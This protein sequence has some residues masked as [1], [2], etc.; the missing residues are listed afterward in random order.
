M[1]T[2]VLTVTA[3][4]KEYS[5]NL[6]CSLTPLQ[7]YYARIRIPQKPV[8]FRKDGVTELIHKVLYPSYI[9]VDS[10]DYYSLLS[11][12]RDHHLYSYLNL[13]GK[14]A[15]E[16]KRVSAKE[17][18]WVKRLSEISAAVF[19]DNRIH[20]TIG[21]L[22]GCDEA[23]KKYDRH[24]RSIMVTTEFLESERDVWLGV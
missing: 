9:F 22:V 15:E 14:G 21:P 24:K 10:P 23:V 13:L 6:L 5:A 16:I 18:E 17:L 1:T 11:A 4:K 12:L 2:C 20:F 7:P 19:T 8:Y 3:L